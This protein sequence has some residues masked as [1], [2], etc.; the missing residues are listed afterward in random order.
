MTGAFEVASFGVASFGIQAIAES[1]ALRIVDC[2]FA[3]TLIAFFAAAVS[4]FSRRQ[5]SSLRFAVWFSALL[6][7]A[8]S[9]F[10]SDAIWAHSGNASSGLSRA[11]IILPGS[12]AIYVFGLWSA[13]AGLLLIRVGI[14]LW[15]LHALRENFVPVDP[16]D[17]DESV[18]ETLR[19]GPDRT[20]VP[21][22][23]SDRVKVPAAIGLI[24]PVV[25]VPHWALDE[26]S[27]D[28]L[29]QVLL[30]EMAHL[31]RRDS[32]TNLAQ[33]VIKAAL[34]FHPAVWWIERELS[35]ERE[36]A[37]DDA[38]LAQTASPR[39]YAECLKHIAERSLV[40][41]TLALAQAVLGR[42]R[43]T[44]AR[45]AR[46]LDATHPRG[47]KQG[48]RSGFS[49]AALLIACS[50]VGA[51]EPHLI[52]FQNAEPM[53][54]NVI[55]PHIPAITP[56]S[57]KT[58]EAIAPGSVSRLNP[59]RAPA[60]NRGVGRNVSRNAS[61]LAT[62]K[63]S[64]LLMAAP[65]DHAGLLH[66]ASVHAPAA[67]RS[68]VMASESVFVVFENC[69]FGSSGQPL[70]E[71]EVVRVTVLRPATSFTGGEILHKEI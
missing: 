9:P 41:R 10:L 8:V 27:S 50:L 61:H 1:S 68:Q 23:T 58:A 6:G 48:W 59:F 67:Q 60:T 40:R 13:I 64:D 4:R 65:K 22:F 17:L 36:M 32:W 47:S 53:Q 57:F 51:N 28:E 11:A 39:A 70:Y 46:I 2:L 71:I 33:Q 12:W 21:L 24:D 54:Q 52:A 42:V 26:L 31:R 55:A 30:H 69:G 7:L 43:Q 37:C 34:F 19:H 18:R 38:V 56:V 3:G 20:S 29:K 25:A 5:S 44:S 62:A 35:L 14:G 63:R 45:V 66:F 16:D 49:L 15:R